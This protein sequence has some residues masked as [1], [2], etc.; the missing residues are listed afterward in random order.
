M[1]QADT[2]AAAYLLARA[3]FNGNRIEFERLAASLR[4][5]SADRVDSEWRSGLKLLNKVIV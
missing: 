1:A 2:D 5:W 4:D 3:V